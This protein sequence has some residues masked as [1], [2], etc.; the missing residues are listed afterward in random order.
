MRCTYGLDD[1]GDCLTG[2]RPTRAWI[3]ELPQ[4]VRTGDV[5]LFSSYNF[6]ANITKCCTVSE[7]DHV[8]VVVRP[9]ASHTYLLEWVS[10]LVACDLVKRLVQYHNVDSRLLC[11][12]RLHLEQVL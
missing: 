1:L 6:G 5:I 9:D 11:V 10:G 3:R 2:R 4:I 12:R 8:G 7:W